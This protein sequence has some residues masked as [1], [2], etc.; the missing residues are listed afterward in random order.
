MQPVA[1]RRWGER[2]LI[3]VGYPGEEGEGAPEEPRQ[4]RL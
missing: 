2:A 4:V 3:P 1:Q